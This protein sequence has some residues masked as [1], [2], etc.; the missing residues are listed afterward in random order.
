[1]AGRVQGLSL[2]HGR[3]DGHDT[4]RLAIGVRAL[5]RPSALELSSGRRAR[6]P[7]LN[8]DLPS[9]MESG[10]TRLLQDLLLALGG[11]GFAVCVGLSAVVDRQRADAYVLGL[12]AA[13]LAFFVGG[14]WVWIGRHSDVFAA[15][16]AA[17][18]AAAVALYA[19]LA[20]QHLR[21]PSGERDTEGWMFA[22]SFPQAALLAAAALPTGRLLGLLTALLVPVQLG[23]AVLLMLERTDETG[24]AISAGSFALW[25]A[26][27]GLLA[28]R[29]GR[30]AFA[31]TESIGVLESDS[32][33]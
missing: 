17:A 19:V 25:A 32:R 14:L 8:G 11:C 28:L 9:N 15:V 6:E 2:G 31:A 33:C 13:L 16:T 18:G 1:M 4:P 3:S 5:H 20:L 29:T 23:A 26:A 21:V 7:W 27:F 22:V 10:A 24:V 30:R 12:A